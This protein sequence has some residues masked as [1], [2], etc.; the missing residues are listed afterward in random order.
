MFHK[1]NWKIIAKTYSE[2]FRE[3]G[4]KSMRGY[5]A[6]LMHGQTIILWECQDKDCQGLRKEKMLGKEVKINKE[7]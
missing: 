3:M 1:H 2:S 5:D 7:K 4:G 6:V